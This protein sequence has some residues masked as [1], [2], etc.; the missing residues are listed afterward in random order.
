[1]DLNET[2]DVNVNWRWWREYRY[3]V[4]LLFVVDKCNVRF[5]PTFSDKVLAF[6]G[7]FQCG[8]ELL[9]YAG[10]DVAYK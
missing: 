2:G 8:N 6:V 1:M 4:I 9:T 5:D 10:E 7:F 3:H